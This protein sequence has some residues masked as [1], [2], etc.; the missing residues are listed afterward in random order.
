MGTRASFWVGDP[1]NI[2]QRQLIGCKAW[3]GYPD[4]PEIAPL[5][6]AATED[7]F[8]LVLKALQNLD[9]W[10]PAENG[11]P[12]PWA[13]DIFLTDYTYA[14][15]DGQCNVACYHHGF[16]AGRDA[17]K[18]GAFDDTDNLPSNVP[19]P[20]GYNPKQPDSVMIIAIPAAES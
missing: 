13:D 6:N 3:D 8:R 19:A 7:E 10:A 12:Y 1:R 18:E 11:W 5:L 15:F 17:T 14:F 2:E 4:N 20:S 16:V 9:D